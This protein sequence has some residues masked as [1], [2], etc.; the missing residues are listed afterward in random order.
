METPTLSS[1]QLAAYIDHAWLKP[2]ATADVIEKLCSEA[3]ELGFYGVCVNG[4]RVD[5]VRYLLEDADIKVVAVI[6]F[7]FGAMSSDV[8]RFET[9]AAVDDGAQEID[10]VINIGRLKE[11]DH[12]FVLRELRDVVEAAE[13]RPVK[14]IIETCLLEREEKIR[15]CELAVESGAQF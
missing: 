12:K 7:P 14:V 13:E 1:S 5:Q 15:A 3:R 11:G 2:D 10:L 4:S 6:G 9:E 8:K